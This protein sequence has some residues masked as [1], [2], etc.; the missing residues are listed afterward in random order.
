[1]IQGSPPTPAGQRRSSPA[2]LTTRFFEMHALHHRASA[3]GL[4]LALVA[5]LAQA[6]SAPAGGKV[7]SLGNASAKAPIMSRDELRTCLKQQADFK[8]R[9]ADMASQRAALDA[10]RQALEKDNAN[11]AQLRDELA[12]KA[13]R[14]ANEVNIKVAAHAETVQKFNAK[15]DELNEAMK[16]REDVA[17]RRANLEREG[18]VIQK[19]SDELNAANAA[20]QADI[21]A[22]QRTLNAKF[23]DFEVR[24]ADWNQ[25]NKQMDPTV[26]N[27]EDDLAAWKT[28]CG[29]R[30]YRETDEQAIRAGK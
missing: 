15:M 6:Q 7:Q 18:A 22:S 25:R 5:G 9:S 30:N 8:T 29:G 16:R 11:L 13:E 1:M 23:A 21:D 14:S 20:A 12:A 27:Y 10:E 3:A 17:R 4:L 2:N 24:I 28:R 19:T 26:A